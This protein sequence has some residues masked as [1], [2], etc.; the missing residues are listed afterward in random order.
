M[1]VQN[2]KFVGFTRSW[3]NRG[4]EKAGR[5]C[6]NFFC[7]HAYDVTSP[8]HAAKSATPTV[9]RLQSCLELKRE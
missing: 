6:V 2:W 9:L 8:A 3:D 4:T 5:N 7:F 1:H